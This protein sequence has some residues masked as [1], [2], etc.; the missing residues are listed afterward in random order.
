MKIA[1]LLNRKN[2]NITVFAVFAV[3]VML[4]PIASAF[5][6]PT[7][8][9][10][11]VNSLP[12]TETWDILEAG[13]VNLKFQG[14][15]EPI[16][17]KIYLENTSP[18]NGSSFGSFGSIESDNSIFIIKRTPSDNNATIY[19]QASIGM[20]VRIEKI[21]NGNHIE[22]YDDCVLKGNTYPGKFN[23]ADN[24]EYA[25]THEDYELSLTIPGL[26]N[27]S[28]EILTD[29]TI[30]FFAIT[31]G[32]ISLFDVMND[33]TTPYEPAFPLFLPV[34]TSQVTLRSKTESEVTIIIRSNVSNAHSTPNNFELNWL[35]AKNLRVTDD[36]IMQNM[37]QIYVDINEKIH[38]VWFEVDVLT[39]KSYIYYKRSDDLGITWTAPSLVVSRNF[40]VIKYLTLEGEGNFLAIAWQEQSIYFPEPN[41]GLMYSTLSN[42][43]GASWT[44]PAEWAPG[45]INPA[46]DVTNNGDIY[47]VI[48]SGS[49]AV[50]GPAK[51]YYKSNGGGLQ[52]Q[53]TFLGPDSEYISGV[54]SIIVNGAEIH[55]TIADYASSYIY[56]WH[57][58]GEGWISEAAMITQYNGDPELGQMDLGINGDEL[59]IVWSDN[60]DGQYDIYYKKQRDGTWTDDIRVTSTDA[61]STNPK[62]AIG[63]SNVAGVHLVWQE[64]DQNETSAHYRSLEDAGSVMITRTKM[65]GDS[66]DSYE[67]SIA[68]GNSGGFHMC[69]VDDRHGSSEVYYANSGVPIISMST[70]LIQDKMVTPGDP[71][72]VSSTVYNDGNAAAYNVP[73][74]FYAFS[75]EDLFATVVIDILPA[76]SSKTVSATWDSLEG[77]HEIIVAI[78]FDDTFSDGA[79][80]SSSIE[81]AV[82]FPPA[83]QAA[84]DHWLA[85]MITSS[86]IEVQSLINNTSEQQIISY[87]ECVLYHLGEA[88]DDC[89]KFEYYQVLD[90]MTDAMAYLECAEY[91][92]TSPPQEIYDLM[93]SL[94]Y[95]MG[96]K[97]TT[98]IDY[99]ESMYGSDSS[100]ILTARSNYD[101]AMNSI[102][103]GCYETSINYLICAYDGAANPLDVCNISFVSFKAENAS[104]PDGDLVS[105]FWDFG[106]GIYSLGSEVS[107]LFLAMGNYDVS[108]VVTDDDGASSNS[109]ISVS[110]EDS[111]YW[112]DGVHAFSWWFHQVRPWNW[113]WASHLCTSWWYMDFPSWWDDEPIKWNYGIDLNGRIHMVSECFDWESVGWLPEDNSLPQNIL[114]DSNANTTDEFSEMAFISNSSADSIK[115][116]FV[117]DMRTDIMYVSWIE[118][119]SAPELVYSS[120]VDSGVSWSESEFISSIPFTNNYD[121]QMKIGT[122]SRLQNPVLDSIEGSALYFDGIDDYVDLGNSVELQT[123]GELTIEAWLKTSI[124]DRYMGI[125]GKL[126][127]NRVDCCPTYSGYALSKRYFIGDENNSKFQFQIEGNGTGEMIYS[128]NAYLDDDWHHVVG[129]RKLVD[130]VY[131]NLLY[132]DGVKQSQEGI[133]DLDDSGGIAF[134]GRQYSDLDLLRM[135]NGSIDEFRI[136]DRALSDGEIL[137]DYENGLDHAYVSRDDTTAWYHLN[138][139]VTDSS[140]NGNNGTLHGPVWTS[141]EGQSMY[142]DGVKDFVYCGNGEELQII[143][144]LT[145]EAWVRPSVLNEYMGIAGKFSIDTS[146]NY[147]G[148]SMAKHSN[149]HFRFL[150]G[151]GGS[152]SEI[153]ESDLAYTDLDW[154]HVAFVRKCVNGVYNNLLFIDGV[155]QSQEGSSHMINSGEFAFIG[156]QYSDYNARYWKGDIDEVRL[157]NVSLSDSEI[158]ADYNEGLANNKYTSMPGTVY[159]RDFNQEIDEDVNLPDG[160]KLMATVTTVF[161]SFDFEIMSD[162][163]GDKIPDTQDDNPGEFDIDMD[164]SFQVDAQHM[165]DDAGA[166]VALDFVNYASNVTIDECTSVPP[167]LSSNVGGCYDISMT[168]SVYFTAAVKIQYVEDDLPA[169]VFEETLRM[170]YWNGTAWIVIPDSGVNSDNNYVWCLVNHFTIFAIGDSSD[171]DTDSDTLPDYWEMTNGLNSGQIN[172]ELADADGDGLYDIEEYNI[173]TNA[174]NT[175]SDNDGL[176]DGQEYNNYFPYIRDITVDKKLFQSSSETYI[177]MND[178]IPGSYTGSVYGMANVN[179]SRVDDISDALNLL[180]VYDDRIENVPLSDSSTGTGSEEYYKEIDVSYQFQFELVDG[181]EQIWI[182]ATDK[183]AEP[184]EFYVYLDSMELKYKGSDPN[185]EDTSN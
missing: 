94:C 131:T 156:R 1:S 17:L 40:Q 113:D 93:E 21:T 139:D 150:V 108:L 46:I 38:V 83:A 29:E 164:V 90:H 61:D 121:L 174:N 155:R 78:D 100:N 184:S 49:P 80:S 140:G 125:G 35:G 72:T 152:S 96:D 162:H 9:I 104:D 114:Y 103:S 11:D 3:A 79:A 142:F 15:S 169:G 154:H 59:F 144:N 64:K 86:E 137:S 24:P 129:V 109:N 52:E 58:N 161:G 69:W 28:L 112:P 26:Y 39:N 77:D 128:D 25:E 30:S 67:P 16:M 63:S 170:Y 74:N 105:Y 55:V 91:E 88:W 158:L 92:Y 148:Y 181:Y 53:Y 182:R 172:S 5:V 102:A 66:N 45:W 76:H 132:V 75:E 107:H 134:I 185:S 119:G 6:N 143:G 36:S 115:P 95:A 141:I 183:F 32:S 27:H 149:N 60:R 65:S 41:P 68:I 54:P 51:L 48:S 145:L 153:I 126:A 146:W 110:I 111:Y 4:L 118:G 70:P 87:L 167:D 101:C 34:G 116:Q 2:K 171:M 117:L 138:N 123:T 7:D 37:P 71:V 179:N 13:P 12:V 168:D 120:S 89:Y 176:T 33:D 97:T 173:G 43:S 10:V 8:W 178:L 82:N 98:F 44:M 124:N 163:D 31:N 166:S 135:W 165:S 57:H 127:L 50:A 122:Y 20:T 19:F 180:I 42:N 73:V 159:Y 85:D 151:G 81:I 99:M 18:V 160:R 62:L 56:Y 14:I 157:L 136:L 175:D 106:N 84:V 133:E 147:N 22:G 23:I 130:G 47:F 177:P